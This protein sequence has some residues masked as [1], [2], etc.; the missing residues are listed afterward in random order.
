V[1][2]VAVVLAAREEADP[3][4]AGLL[5]VLQRLGELLEGLAL[6]GGLGRVASAQPLES[7]SA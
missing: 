5:Q 3:L 7:S 6:D 1:A 2:D 4:G